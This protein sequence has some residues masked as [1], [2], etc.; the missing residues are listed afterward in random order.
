[1]AAA[2]KNIDPRG[3]SAPAKGR[4]NPWVIA[5]VVS[6]AAFMEVLDTSIANVALPYMAGGLASSLDDASWVLTSYLVANAIV[7]PISGWLSIRIGRKRFYMACVVI[8]TIS[9][10][11]CGI[12]PSLG[13]LI[14]F[15]VIQGAGGG[16]LQ[17]VSQAILRDS[18]PPEQLGA[19]FAVYGMVVVLAPAIGPT[20][21]GWI[22]DNYQ[23]RWIFY[24]NVPVGILSLL[25]VSRLIEDPGYL[26]GQLKKLRGHMSIDYIGIGL[27]ALCLGALQVVLDKGQE[28]NWFYSPM[29]ATLEVIFPVALVL[30]I[31]WELT[32][33]KPV[34]DLRMF[35]NLNFAATAAMIFAYGVVVYGMTV[36][37]PQYVQ[38]YVGYDA[39][40]AGKTQLF[41]A[42]LLI[43]LMPLTAKLIRWIEARW[44][45]GVGFL[46]TALASFYVTTNL[47]LQ[48][49]FHTAA[50]YR[51]WLSVGLALLFVPINTA[52]YVGIPEEKGGEVSGTINLLRNIGGSVGISMVETMIARREQF[53]QDI[54]SV[55][56][57]RARQAYRNVT[58]G[59]SA[60]L[61]H[62]GLTQ[63]QAASQTTLRLYNSVVTQAYVLSYIDVAWLIGVMCLLMIPLILMLKQNNPKAAV[64]SA[65]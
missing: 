11:L 57:T 29:I 23:W 47:D 17:P 18:F 39:E 44:L 22:T 36:F 13:M 5:A 33:D 7:L 16:G 60:D 51:V 52:S 55:H 3:S 63:P 54:L 59:L 19:A 20:I 15:R 28:D 46:L 10:F 27:L 56:V 31:A 42:A 43:L 65:E 24:M 62:R 53:H 41:G 35:K 21:G 40:L 12:A 50:M 1:M 4:V 2:P 45:I 49:S 38:A 37:T 8:F 32:R 14:L 30:F 6:I 64:A 48:I 25:L 26:T 61:F 34:M 9:S 58:S